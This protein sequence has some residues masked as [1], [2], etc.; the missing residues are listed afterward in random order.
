MTLSTSSVGRTLRTRGR[1][2]YRCFILSRMTAVSLCPRPRRFPPSS[3]A[4][5]HAMCARA[6]PL[7][8]RR[9]RSRCPRLTG[10]LQK[11]STQLPRRNALYS[12]SRHRSRCRSQHQ[13]RSYHQS[14]PVL[15]GLWQRWIATA[16][17]LHCNFAKATSSPS[18]PSARMAGGSGNL[19]G[20]LVGCIIPTW[21]Q[22]ASD[23]SCPRST[24]R[25]VFQPFVL[26]GICL[27]SL[28]CMGFD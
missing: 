13:R 1:S 5:L 24:R 18:P 27:R 9:G 25:R 6:S 10:E 14:P 4:F 23:C 22:Q 16:H 7:Q 26:S 3:Q 8:R 20:K 11:S 17:R 21:H 28:S 19:T 12:S 15:Y 2:L